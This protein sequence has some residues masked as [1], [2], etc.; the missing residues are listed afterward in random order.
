MDGEAKYG[1]G[2][3]NTQSLLEI[4]NHPTL[5]TWREGV[6]RKTVGKPCATCT[7]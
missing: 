7:Y 6:S 3:V 5:K 4:Y 1:F 2:D